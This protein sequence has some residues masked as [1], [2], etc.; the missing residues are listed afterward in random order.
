M[1]SVMDHSPGQGQFP[2][3][4]KFFAYY[5]KA[6]NLTEEEARELAETKKANAK[7]GW[8]RAMDLLCAVEA[9]IP[10]ASHDDDSEDRVRFIQELAEAY[11]NFP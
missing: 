9:N 10:A 8:E 11:L 6:Y 5:G 4:E 2:N 3:F 7:S 1:V